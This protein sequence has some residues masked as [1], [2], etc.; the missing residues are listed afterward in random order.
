MA[1]E[2]QT[3]PA[4]QSPSREPIVNDFSITI[5]TKNGSGVRLQMPQFAGVVKMGIPVSGKYLPPTFKGCP[6]GIP[7]A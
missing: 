7:S 3:K 6:L 1:V 5:A 4:T 2:V